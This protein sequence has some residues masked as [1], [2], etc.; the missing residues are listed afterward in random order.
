[1]VR[2]KV[3]F[4]D[5]DAEK[6]IFGDAEFIDPFVKVISDQG[7]TVYINKDNIVFMKELLE[8]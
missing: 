8:D 7:N 2:Y 4:K 1:M 6:R 5:G 3:V